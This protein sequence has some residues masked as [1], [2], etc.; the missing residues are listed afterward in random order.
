MN[1]KR[2]ALYILGQVV[3]IAVAGVAMFWPAGRIDWWAAWAVLGVWVLWFTA[4]DFVIFRLNPELMAERMAP[5]KDAKGWDRAIL[6]IIRLIELARYIIAGFDQ[7]YGWTEGFPLSA[8]IVAVIVCVLCAAVFAWA[9]ASNAYFSQVVRIQSDRGHTVA[10]GGPYSYVR[11]PSY[12]ST[13]VFELAI[14]TVLASW[15]AIIAGGLCVILFVIRTAL[16]DRTLQAEL[17]GYVDYTRQVRYRLVPGV[18]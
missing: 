17:P 12:L 14:S 16:E 2:V 13:M 4:V 9:M 18:W 8:Q 6:S 11:H 1:T 5:P 3:S 7:R 15:W 10:T